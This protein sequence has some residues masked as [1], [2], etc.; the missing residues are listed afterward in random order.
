M[1]WV[2]SPKL[3]HVR[4]YLKIMRLNSLTGAFLLLWPC[5]WSISLAAKDGFPVVLA[6]MFIV[7]AFV[8]RSAG[9]VIN[10]IVDRKIDAKVKRTKGRP[11]A[12]GTMKLHEAFALLILLLSMGGAILFNL[13]DTA[14]ILGIVIVVP[15]F[16]YPLMKRVTYWPQVFLALTFNWGAIIGWA[17]V[18]D[19][20]SIEAVLLYVACIFWTLAYDTIYAHQDKE[21]DAMMGM[22]S[23]ALKFGANTKKYLYI[24]YAAMVAILWVVGIRMGSGFLFHLFLFAGAIQLFWQVYTLHIDKADSCMEKFRSN[25]YFGAIIFLAFVLGNV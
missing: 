15:I 22:K 3:V 17:A 18:R 19:S 21:D 9:C 1:S 10:D 20:I 23:T 13:N 14:I 2:D 4:P 7:G 24:F 25:R 12:N 16:I 11:L 5:L 6:L 8:M